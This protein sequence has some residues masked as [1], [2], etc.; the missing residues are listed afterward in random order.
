MWD[1][2]VIGVFV[3]IIAMVLGYRLISRNIEA[4]KL[5]AQARL[6]DDADSP[7]AQLQE[8]VLAIKEMLAD[9]VLEGH[10]GSREALPPHADDEHDDYQA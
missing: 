3:P 5:E 1:P 6:R 9:V 10:V 4:K 2:G 7:I 8:D